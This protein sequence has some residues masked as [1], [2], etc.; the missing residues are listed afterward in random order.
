MLKRYTAIR[1]RFKKNNLPL[2]V[3]NV[4]E[5]LLEI[6]EIC[7]YSTYYNSEDKAYVY[8]DI[9]VEPFEDNCLSVTRGLKEEE[10]TRNKYLLER[11]DSNISIEDIMYVDY[12]KE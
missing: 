8:I 12:Y 2:E 4:S 1:I 11:I 5:L 10:F 6:S 9:E 3:D 7:D